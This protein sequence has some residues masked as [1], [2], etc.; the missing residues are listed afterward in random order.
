MDPTSPANQAQSAYTRISKSL[1]ALKGW[2]ILWI[3]AFH[4]IGN[5]R[6]YLNLGE[7][8]N[9]LSQGNLKSVIDATLELTIAAGN[10]GVNIFLVVSGFGLT[11]SWWK[12]Y[13]SQGTERIPLRDFWQKRVFRIFPLFWISVALAALLYTANASWAPFGQTLWQS[14]PLTLLSVFLATITTLRNVIPEYYY[15]LNGAWWYIGLSLQLYFIFPVLI[16]VGR[17]VGWPKLLLGTL[18]FSFA[19]R[20]VFAFA[21]IDS[22]WITIAFD[23]FP[24]RVFDFTFGIYLAITLL[25]STQSNHLQNL[26]FNPLYLPVNLFFFLAGL[27]LKWVD[28]PLFNIFEDAVITVSLFCTLICLSQLAS[29]QPISQVTDRI[30]T[31][32]IG[33]LFGN[34]SYGIYLT[35]MNIY[36]VLWP[37]ATELLPSYWPRFVVVT[38][39][40]CWLGVQFERAYGLIE[41][42]FRRQ[43]IA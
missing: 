34:Y 10:A 41:S 17:Q 33:A 28:H 9:T 19:Y 4:L 16:Q 2:A 20:A 30:I 14:G 21:S 40:C 22:S 8:L 36:L 37:I 13:G 24:A 7:S 15:F 11:A 32:V 38:L 43:K 12:K 29:W 26:L 31:P 42:Q 23:F 5:T 6:G 1:P 35:H 18:L 25:T 27:I 3:V 39:L